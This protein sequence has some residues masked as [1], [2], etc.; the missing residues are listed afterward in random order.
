VVKQFT[1]LVTNPAG[2]P[3]YAKRIRV[4]LTEAVEGGWGLPGHAHTN[5]ELVGAARVQIA[6]LSAEES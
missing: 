6:E 3:E 5:G 4:L 1:S 2:N